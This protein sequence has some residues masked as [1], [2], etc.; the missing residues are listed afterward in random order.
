MLSDTVTVGGPATPPTFSKVFGQ[1]E[2][3]PVRPGSFF[4]RALEK[5]TESKPNMQNQP[6][7]S[8]RSMV[9]IL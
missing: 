7:A 8:R 1:P 6:H 2:P 4:V 3:G 9:F 5:M